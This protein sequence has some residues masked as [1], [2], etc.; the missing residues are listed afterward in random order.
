MINIA[1]MRVFF[2]MMSFFFCGA[3]SVLAKD[4]AY[5]YGDVA[6]D[7]TVPSG[8][9]EPYDQM[10][11][12]NTGKAGCSQFRDM[13]I[14]QGYTITAHYDVGVTLDAAFLA[15]YDVIVFGLHQRLWSNIE[16]LALD[17]WLRAGGGILIY[18]DSASGGLHSL[19]GIHND[20][21]QSVVNNLISQYG[22][23]VTVDQG[24][25]TRSYVPDEGS[26]NSI[27]WD[28][29]EF[30]GE[31][32]SPVAVSSDPVIGASAHVLIPLAP[33]YRE[34]G[35][36]DLSID[37]RNI[38]LSNYEWASIA[39]S[40]VG[41]GNV[42]A[43][44]DRQPMWNLGSVGSDIKKED[45]EE[46]LRRVIR[47]LARDYGN[48]DEWL[49]YKLVGHSASSLDLS[50]RQ[51]N[52]GVG[53]AG[54]TYTARNNVFQVEYSTTLEQGT[55]L[56][57]PSLLTSIGSAVD[58]GD[59][60]ETVTVR[61]Q[62]PSSGEG[63]LYARVKV[64]PVDQ[65]NAM[66]SADAGQDRYIGESGRVLLS[67]T[68]SDGGL[69][70]EWAQVSGPGSVTFDDMFSSETTATFSSAGTYRISLT[71]S[72]GLESVA[73]ILEVRVVDHDDVVLAVN[74]GNVSA[75]HQGLNGFSYSADTD[76]SLFSG[77]RI[78]AFTGNAVAGT[79]DDSLYNYARTEFDDYSVPLANG[80]YTIYAQHAETFFTQG[81][82]RVFNTFLEGIP[83]NEGLDLVVTAPGRWVAYDRAYT[84][85]VSDGELTISFESTANHN[86]LNAFVI[87]KE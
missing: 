51:W 59:E 49:D 38:T 41:E 68:V 81:G 73:D 71:A 23:E 57:D 8:S 10:L 27:I 50:Y 4:V 48:S 40:Q 75:G 63:A 2:L 60:T 65:V 83:V 35:G 11:L 13:V 62:E 31:G 77:G 22:L 7:G 30:E 12:S 79:E 46:I 28:A 26:S 33:E 34:N 87:I 84:T 36:S 47:Y 5:I 72:N 3:L 29:P 64:V 16:K 25:G 82:S 58:N 18:S 42:I 67:G 74:C 39:L 53:D 85:T 56:V 37:T 55:W 32:V 54:D 78:D 20:I 76:S 86:L 43:T 1:S 24:G 52:G 6:P 17:H 44:F 45:N 14:S 19:V 80:V 21:G 61:L 9:V 66:I 70:T 15:Q 69:T